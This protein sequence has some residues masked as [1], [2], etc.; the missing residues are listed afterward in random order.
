MRRIGV[1]QDSIVEIDPFG[2]R[3]NP[4]EIEIDL[5][6]LRPVELREPVLAH[7]DPRRRAARRNL[8]SIEQVRL[9]PLDVRADLLLRDRLIGPKGRPQGA[10]EIL[11]VD[12]EPSPE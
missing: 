1:E 12:F 6:V 9:D 7:G 3:G 4:F 2:P 5:D 8:D 10:I 11:D